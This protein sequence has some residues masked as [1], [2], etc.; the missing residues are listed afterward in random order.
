MI[1]PGAGLRVYRAYSV[2]DMRKG[3]AWLAAHT[4]LVLKQNLASGAVF[5]YRRRHGDRIK[6]LFW[7]GHRRR[8]ESRPSLGR[9][10]ANMLIF[11]SSMCPSLGL[12]RRHGIRDAAGTGL[13]PHLITSSVRNILGGCGLALV[14][15]VAIGR[16]KGLAAP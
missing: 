8:P 3:I 10:I 16:L 7:D 14:S 5:C 12:W 9:S 2:T 6:L 4:Q 11:S 1:A 15:V 13:P